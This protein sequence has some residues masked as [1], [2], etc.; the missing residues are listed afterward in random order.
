MGRDYNKLPEL[1]QEIMAATACV[2]DAFERY[3]TSPIPSKQIG[4][5]VQL[6]GLEIRLTNIAQDIRERLL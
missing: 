3:E 2:I 4:L 1:L 6:S 5:D